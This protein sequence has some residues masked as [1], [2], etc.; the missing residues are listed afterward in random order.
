MRRIEGRGYLCG[1]G[2]LVALL[3]TLPLSAAPPLSGAI[4]TT[5]SDGTVVN[6]NT[7]YESKCEV[8]LDGGPGPHAPA[9][10]AG[11]PPGDYY[12][13]VTDPSG[14]KLLSTDAVSNRQ[15][16]VSADGVIVAEAGV[17]GPMHPTGTDVDQAGLGAITIQLANNTCPLDFLDTPN[18]GGVYKA[19]IT[20]VGDGTVAG[21]GFVGDPGEVD[22]PCGNGCFHGF[23]PA[24]SKTDNFK[25][26]DKTPTFCIEVHKFWGEKNLRTPLEGW[27]ITLTDPLG[28][29]NM[30]Y[31]GEDGSVEICGLV[32]GGY[33]VTES[34]DYAYN[35]W[36]VVATEVNG[37]SV[38][39]TTSVDIV[40]RNNR[41]D[42]QVV[43]F[44][45]EVCKTCK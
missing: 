43:T 11:L 19:W 36:N 34:L 22:N 18:N 24:R 35:L 33:T 16:T 13:Q 4:F 27:E 25:V 8:Y 28:V 44:V 3:L 31:T 6:G 12:Y 9:G 23:I 39:P 37:S 45:N 30:Y 26:S 38:T 41:P 29:E 20:P 21:G 40:W 15:F 10:A 14:K 32:A 2:L 1:L 7:K 17:G 42:P 5:T